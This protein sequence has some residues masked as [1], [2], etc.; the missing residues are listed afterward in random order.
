MQ[1]LADRARETSHKGDDLLQMSTQNV[2]KTQ[3]LLK[4][5]SHK[6]TE[7]ARDMDKRLEKVGRL[8]VTATVSLAIHRMRALAEAAEQARRG[9]SNCE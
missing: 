9:K 7:A 4:S 2:G 3:G 6:S 8:K 1:I 5:E